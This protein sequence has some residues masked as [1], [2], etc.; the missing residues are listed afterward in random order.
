MRTCEQKCIKRHV[1]IAQKLDLIEQNR[2]EFWIQ[3]IRFILNQLKK[4]KQQFVVDQCYFMLN[5]VYTYILY[6]YDL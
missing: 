2:C 4:C 3:R 5:P 1:A 6:I